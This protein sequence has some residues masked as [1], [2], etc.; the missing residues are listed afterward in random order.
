M[1]SNDVNTSEQ[2]TVEMN[3]VKLLIYWQ[4]SF[5]HGWV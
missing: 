3:Y 4:C 2:Y 1:C 5:T